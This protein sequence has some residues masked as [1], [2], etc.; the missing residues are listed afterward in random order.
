[1]R[2]APRRRHDR[3]GEL[4]RQPDPVAHAKFGH[5]VAQHVLGIAV[6]GRGVDDAGAA[7]D[8]TSQHFLQ[9][10]AAGCIHLE[11]AEVPIPITG[12]DSPVAGSH[13]RQAGLGS[14][15]AAKLGRDAARPPRRERGGREKERRLVMAAPRGKDLS[16]DGA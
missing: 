10:P 9:R 3:R 13:V 12:M 15:V 6:V 4:G 5:Q 16:G 7:V 14:G 2:T 8:K 1:V 11:T